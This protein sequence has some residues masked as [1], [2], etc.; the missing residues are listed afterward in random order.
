MLRHYRIQLFMSR[1]LTAGP[2]VRG[3]PTNLGGPRDF[4]EP[5]KSCIKNEKNSSS[6]LKKIYIYGLHEVSFG[7]GGG[8]EKRLRLRLHDME[9][10]CESKTLLK[11]YLLI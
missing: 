7:G 8:Q 4:R 2:A 3:R 10:I 11:I 9:Y 5:R 6:Y 1:G